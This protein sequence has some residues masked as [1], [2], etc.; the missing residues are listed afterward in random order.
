MKKATLYGTLDAERP[1]VRLIEGNPVVRKP[2]RIAWLC[3]LA[4]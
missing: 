1:H 4:G 2:G 3:K